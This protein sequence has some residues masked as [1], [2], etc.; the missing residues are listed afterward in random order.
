MKTWLTA[1]PLLCMS[2]FALAD[3]PPAPPE[4]VQAQKQMTAQEKAR[5]KQRD[6]RPCLDKKS[7]KDIHRCAAGKHK[8]K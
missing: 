3:E 6:M 7:N 1:L 8:R 4:I 5:L 2:P